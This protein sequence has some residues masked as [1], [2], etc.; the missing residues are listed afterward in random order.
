MQGLS[1][2]RPLK[3]I[4]DR[5]CVRSAPSFFFL[6][7]RVAKLPLSVIA[8]FRALD[9]HHCHIVLIL[10]RSV[11]IVNQDNIFLLANTYLRT[12]R[13]PEN[14]NWC[15]F[16]DSP[17]QK[18]LERVLSNELGLTNLALGVL[19]V[20]ALLYLAISYLNSRSSLELPVAKII[21]GN[22]SDSLMEARALVRIKFPTG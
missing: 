11:V 9:Y 15:K 8:V 13:T 18:M 10:S 16:G 20:A 4:G 14:L 6:C 12:F 7:Y 3:A 19:G 5:R 1:S 2:L 17:C 21:P 22:T